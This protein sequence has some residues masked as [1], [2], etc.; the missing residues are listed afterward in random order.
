MKVRALRLGH[1]ANCSS[2][3]SAVDLLFLSA[4]AL[5][6]V[7]AGLAAALDD[8]RG[9]PPNADRARDEPWGR[10]LRLREPAALVALA[11]EGV[12]WALSDAPLEVHLAVTSR[13]GAGCVGCYVDARPDGLEPSY[14]ELVARLD[15]IAV[16]GAFTVAFGGGEPTTRRDLARLADAARARGLGAV[17]TTSGL[18]LTERKIE[19]LRAFDQVNVSYD[20]DAERYTSVRGFDG[21]SEVEASVRALVAA[22]IRVGLNVVLTRTTFPALGALLERARALGAREAQLLRYKPAGRAVSLAYLEQRLS[23]EQAAALGPTLRALAPKLP[24]R[25]D[26]ALVPFL[27]ADPEL[28][29]GMRLARAGVLGCEAGRALAATTVEGAAAPC[30]FAGATDEATHRRYAEAFAAP[31]EP[32][33]SCTLRD[34]CRGGCRVVS[35]HVAG[36]AF[37]P[38]PECP[39]VLG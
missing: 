33:E 8:D 12:P 30:S 22:G 6:A 23:R 1:G 27:S 2:L 3:G 26:C 36:D 7:F 24:L 29:D 5:T 25:I 28:A 14:D 15:A 4:T 19:A 20:G 21:A 9:P 38:D 11:E 34:V 13:C 31:P 39:R 18:G 37:V 32:C 35:R 10:W 16:R 17:V